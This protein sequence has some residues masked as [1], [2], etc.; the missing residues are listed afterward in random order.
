VKTLNNRRVLLGVTGG[1]AAYKAAELLRQCQTLGAEVKVVMT[2]AATEFVTP[3]TF[4]ALSGSTVHTQ[5]LNPEEEAAMG[6]IN[7]ARWADLI[8]VAPASANFIARLASGVANDLLST[9]LLATEKP[10]MVV[11]AMNQAMFAD[12][13]TQ[14]N[15]SLIKERGVMIEGPAEGLQACGDSGFGRMLEPV[16]IVG[17]I[18]EHFQTGALAGVNILL[19]AGPT[20]E[21]I[22][23][24]R[25]ISNHS[26]GK[27][28]FAL[29]QACAD[30]GACVTLVAG[31]VNLE[32]P[33]GVERVN[34][35]NAKEMAEAALTASV[36]AGIFIAVA[37]V[38]D[39]TPVDVPTKKV[40]KDAATLQVE[41][42]KTKDILYEVAHLKEAP[43]CVGFAAE[44]DDLEKYARSKL[45]KK[46]LDMVAANWVGQDNSGFNSD[47][48]ALSVYWRG[49]QQQLAHMP[50]TVLAHK[51]IELIAEKYHEKNST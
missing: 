50:K 34:V 33:S 13:A 22:D 11:P 15:L 41:L 24:V 6:H 48:N 21:A 47:D 35:I 27:M 42:V 1:I 5:L 20:R 32:T 7:L 31:P 49:G 12:S 14:T 30:A 39:Y 4:Q 45:E 29:A 51:L 18:V 43:F 19:T 46:S 28:G 40:K 37:A 36:E 17:S 44:T 2:Q 26:S 16:E 3:L 25:Y 8:V 10:I 9:V 38:A 23:P